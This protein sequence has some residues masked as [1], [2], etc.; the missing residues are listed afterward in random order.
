MS[1]RPRF[2]DLIC[3]GKKTVELR[4]RSPKLSAG[5]TIL[6]YVSS[7]TKALAASFVVDEVS[8][9]T[10]ETIWNEVEHRAGVERLEFDS[11]FLGAE[12]AVAIGVKDP[13]ALREPITLDTLRELWE[14]FTAPQ[15]YRYLDDDM[16]FSTRLPPGRHSARRGVTRRRGGDSSPL[17]EW[18]W[19]GGR[20]SRTTRPKGTSGGSSP[21][22]RERRN[23]DV[24]V[25]HAAPT[26]QFC[27]VLVGPLESGD[28]HPAS[29]ADHVVEARTRENM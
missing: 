25:Y 15:S 21:S 16:V 1:I 29:L 10:P 3:E 28:F 2:A 5:D 18:R 26:G 24:T 7:P 20:G 12:T 23:P 27:S 8:E 17:P 19:Y 22:A 11:Y 13:V 6:L 4:R 9:G 14:P